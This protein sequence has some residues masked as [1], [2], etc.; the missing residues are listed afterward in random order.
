MKKWCSRLL[1][2][3]AASTLSLLCPAEVEGIV[4]SVKSTGMAATAIAYPQDSLVAA[5]NPAG[6]IDVG[7]RIDLECTW[8]QDRGY[9]RIKDNII[10]GVNGKF[11]AYR[12]KDF[13]SPAFGFTK[14]LGCNQAIG[15]V[16]YNRNFSKTTYSTNFPLFGTS[17]L[18]L[19]Y[20]HETISPTYAIYLGGGH[21]IGISGD[22]MIQRMKLNGLE[23]IA[24][25]PFNLSS[26]PENLTNRGYSYAHGFTVTLGWKWQINEDLAIGLTFRPRT[27]MSHFHKYKGFLAQRGRLDIPQKIG[28]GICW[29]PLCCW[30]LC[31]D[32]EH[33]AWNNVRSLRNPLLPNL[34]ESQLGRRDGAGFG[35][36]NHTY[37][38]FG[39]D[40]QVTDNL[41]VRAG[42]RYA[43]T[44]IRSNQ[45]A[46]NTLT[47]DVTEAF[48]TFGATYAFEWC[49]LCHEISAF[50]AHG[51]SKTVKGHHSIPPGLPPPYGFGFGGGDVDL[52]QEKDAAGLA[53]GI[54]F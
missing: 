30:T 39:T 38:R 27:H 37:F 24:A 2:S 50:Y 21:S 53:W 12:T 23:N 45:T 32:V 47:D 36:R 40:Y 31:F 19:E 18:G 49:N 11:D 15:L 4:A 5:Y 51:F 26:D 9:A 22:I 48:L 8:S 28:A 29:R 42:F 6:I 54:N 10:P 43:R 44:P 14:Q 16:V 35:F 46:V 7:D 33:I 13:Y 1:L 20:L 52:H 41:T 17:D 25:S 34:F 3:L